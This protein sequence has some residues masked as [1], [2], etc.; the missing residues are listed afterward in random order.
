MFEIIHNLSVN[1]QVY[2]D[3]DV[4]QISMGMLKP[5]ERHLLAGQYCQSEVCN[6][7]F[8]QFF[9]NGT[10][11]LAPEARDAYEAIG[12]PEWTA[13][14][15]DAMKFF[16][17][18]YPRDR[19]TR[20]AKLDRGPTEVLHALDERFYAWKRGAPDRW[21]EIADAYAARA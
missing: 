12:I 19:E 2:D 15:E 17:P 6:G 5:V 8:W 21:F 10:G 18:R 16:G 14:L 9:Y 13:C 20:I 1:V 3:P 4:F 7:G 11:V